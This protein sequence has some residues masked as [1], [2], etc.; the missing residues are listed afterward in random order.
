VRQAKTLSVL[1]RIFPGRAHDHVGVAM[2]ISRLKAA[3][4]Y[5]GTEDT[6]EICVLRVLTKYGAAARFI[7]LK[8]VHIEGHGETATRRS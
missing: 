2:T 7:R 5:A 6:L 3:S 8:Q 4:E 1:E